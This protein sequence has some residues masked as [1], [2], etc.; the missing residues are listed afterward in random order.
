M[1]LKVKNLNKT[2]PNGNAALQI[3]NLELD[4]GMFG[5][6]GPNGAG[7]TTLMRIIALLLEQSQGE[8]YIFNHNTK[9]IRTHNIIREQIGYLPQDFGVLPYLTA[10]EYL[11]YFYTLYSS[12]TMRKIDKNQRIHEMLELVGLYQERKLKTSTFSGGMKRRLGIAQALIHNPKILIIDEPTSGLDPEE[13]IIFRNIISELSLDMLVVLSTHIIEDI[14]VTCNDIAIIDKGKIIYRGEPLALMKEAN[15]KVF[16]VEIEKEK[17]DEIQKQF[18]VT[19]IRSNDNKV[20]LNLISEKELDFAK[21]I[22]PSLEEAYLY[23]MNCG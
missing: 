2:Y 8:L 9:D 22:E 12:N 13:R 21:A 5:L 18:L 3:I 6:L 11:E 7:K 23:K 16:Q 14:E 20:T 19:R 10:F 15:G 17:I 4:K 1:L